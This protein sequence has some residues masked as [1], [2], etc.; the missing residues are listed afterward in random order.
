MSLMWSEC[1]F[2]HTQTPVCHSA[3]QLWSQTPFIP[4]RWEVGGSVLSP[5]VWETQGGVPTSAASELCPWASCSVPRA[6]PSPVMSCR[7]IGAVAPGSAGKTPWAQG[8]VACDKRVQSLLLPV[9]RGDED[10]PHVG[11]EESEAPQRGSSRR[12]R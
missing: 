8:L 10:Y 2:L 12:Q 1:L 3:P 6:S 4:Q 7:I 11:D 5:R 9:V